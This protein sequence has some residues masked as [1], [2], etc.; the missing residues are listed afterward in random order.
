M[1]RQISTR[2]EGCARD[3]LALF[4]LCG[5][6]CVLF[7]YGGIRS[8]DGEV[9]FRTARSLALSG[10]FAVDEELG[11][12]GFGL[13]TGLDGQRYSIFGPLLPLVTVP[14]VWA[15]ESIADSWVSTETTVPV[16][17]Y[18]GQ[19]NHRFDRAI[20]DARPHAV[21][22]VATQF[23]G[24]ATAAGVVL[25]YWIALRL[26]GSREG[27]WL[28]ALTYGLG[29]IALPYS[30]LFMSEPLAVFLVLSSF[31]ALLRAGRVEFLSAG[32]LLGLATLAHLTAVL[33]A[34]FF[35]LL[36]AFD[37]SEDAG[38]RTRARNVALLLAGLALPLLWLAG[39]NFDRF[40]S[41]FET[42]RTL[43]ESSG[44]GYGV[45]VSPFGNLWG[46]LFG[47][48][49]GLIPFS[50]AILIASIGLRSMFR[51][52][53]RLVWIL[54]AA[55]V[56]RVVFIAARSDWH[57]GFGIGPR[58]LAMLVPFLLLPL[59]FLARDVVA[60][61]VPARVAALGAAILACMVQQFYFSMND[62]YTYSHMLRVTGGRQGLNVFENNFIY[63]A[64]E[65]SPLYRLHEAGLGSFALSQTELGVW[66]LLAALAGVAGAGL[67]WQLYRFTR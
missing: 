64:W 53:R 46:L 30:S 60:S 21:R 58:Y 57:G 67:G 18:I 4:A 61:R 9:G 5:V 35:A 26:S 55:A 54:A 50:P 2:S 52:H 24:L 43:P 17:F 12:K 19:A 63:L 32:L 36:V 37:T 25:F 11:W 47:L 15:G 13:A 56:V 16:S 62:I 10:E 14:W 66:P 22:F 6:A 27:A 33:F 45:F 34:P 59:A 40:G 29:S 23:N 8:P 28:A 41:I 44:F 42:G 31:A 39:F 20:T 3:A 1:G 48:G 49:K 38:L 65:V 7:S 51:E